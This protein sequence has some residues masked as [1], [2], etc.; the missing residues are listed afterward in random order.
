MK[1]LLKIVIVF[2]EKIIGPIDCF[3][4]FFDVWH[5]IIVFSDVC[6]LIIFRKVSFIY[7]L[8]KWI[9]IIDYTKYKYL[10]RINLN[11]SYEIKSPLWTILWFR[12]LG[13]FSVEN[14]DRLGVFMLQTWDNTAQHWFTVLFSVADYCLK[15]ET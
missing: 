7:H 8:K 5:I 1:T 10:A 12:I 13:I 15:F 11:Q 2:Q 3:S 6:K 14:I 4:F 9:E